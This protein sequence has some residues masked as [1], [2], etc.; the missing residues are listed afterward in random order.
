MFSRTWVSALN[1]NPNEKLEYKDVPAQRRETFPPPL[2]IMNL[3]LHL[4]DNSQQPSKPRNLN[5]FSPPLANH[6]T[7]SSAA[8]HKLCLA[9]PH[10][11]TSLSVP[12][13][14]NTVMRPL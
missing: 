8:Q 4:S 13:H 9:K 3:L 7:T 12:P 11:A 5:T 10:Q 2:A 1:A 6:S 14:L